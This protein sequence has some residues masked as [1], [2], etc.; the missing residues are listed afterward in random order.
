MGNGKII[1]CAAEMPS[2]PQQQVM[3]SDIDL[4]STKHGSSIIT[5]KAYR[6]FPDEGGVRLKKTD[7]F[8]NAL[9]GVKFK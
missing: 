7:E 8:G 2:G 9:A 1:H 6:I 5:Y 4:L 3:I